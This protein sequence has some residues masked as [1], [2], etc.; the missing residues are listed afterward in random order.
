MLLDPPISFA[1]GS[2]IS[3]GTL[4]AL[5]CLA[6]SCAWD[7]SGR[8]IKPSVTIDDRVKELH[9]LLRQIQERRS[10]DWSEARDSVVL[11]NHMIATAEHGTRH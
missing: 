7:F 2:P 1:S 9:L 10:H 11:L 4:D 5:A 8:P 3:P 6:R